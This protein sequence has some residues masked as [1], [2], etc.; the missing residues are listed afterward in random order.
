MTS[1]PSR[2]LM[3]LGVW[4]HSFL[5]LFGRSASMQLFRIKICGITRPED[6]RLAAACG[7][8]A[9]GLNFVAGSPRCLD[10]A[11][12]QAVAAALP[13]GV[14]RVGVFAGMP[15]AAMHEIA[16]AVGLDAIQLHGELGAVGG[17]LETEADDADALGRVVDPPQ[18]CAELLPLPVIRAVHLEADGLAAANRWMEAARAAGAGPAMLLVDAAVARETAPGARGGTGRTV[19]W[20][21]VA[22]VQADVPLVLAGGLTPANVADAI[23]VSRVAAVDVA[24]G[25]ESSPGVKDAASLRQF[26]EAALATLPA[27]ESHGAG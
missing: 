6:G 16:D 5:V 26:I 12:A 24:S 25:V 13:P 17:L 20:P 23:A 15:A 2:G 21:A 1:S 19:D 18:R 22:T 27:W 14:V 10:L 11:R 7:A 3:I 8:D 9:I 4:L